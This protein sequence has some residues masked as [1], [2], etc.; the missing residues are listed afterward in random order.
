M[1]NY[2]QSVEK[3]EKFIKNRQLILFLLFW[4][5]I[6]HIWAH[7]LTSELRIIAVEQLKYLK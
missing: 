6:G 5:H 3:S 1:I 2:E 7:F 4:A